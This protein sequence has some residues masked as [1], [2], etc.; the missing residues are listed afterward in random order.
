MLLLSPGPSGIVARLVFRI[1]MLE[2]FHGLYPSLSLSLSLSSITNIINS[3]QLYTVV[4]SLSHEI[5]N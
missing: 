1:C 3:S 5:L 2:I 4:T